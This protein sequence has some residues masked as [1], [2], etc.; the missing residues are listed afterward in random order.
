MKEQPDYNLDRTVFFSDAVF[1]IAMT[2]LALDLPLPEGETNAEI[3]RSFAENLDDGYLAFVIS[4]L[5]IAMFWI[6]HHRFFQRIARLNTS[7]VVFNLLS[8]FS[9][10]VVPF[11]TRA[12]PSQGKFSLG[13]ILYSCV[14]LL[15]GLAFVLMVRAAQRGRLWRDGTPS[16]TPGDLIFGTFAGLSMFAVSIPLA[17]I[18]PRLAQ[19][20]WVLIPVVAA[21]AGRLR[22]R[23]RPSPA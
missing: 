15:W 3:W 16:S 17:L 4:F 13:P 19:A 6:R 22:E 2:L 18:D 11:A 10:I 5:V 1:A 23:G 14:M 20:S 9:I 7:L 12:L 21:T 8:L